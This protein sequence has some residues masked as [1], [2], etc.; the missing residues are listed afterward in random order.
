MTESEK[1]LF[2]QREY[3]FKNRYYTFYVDRVH[4]INL[5]IKQDDIDNDII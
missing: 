2:L 1:K 3:Y 4:F 5:E